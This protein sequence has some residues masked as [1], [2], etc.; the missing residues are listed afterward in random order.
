METVFQR[1][2]DGSLAEHAEVKQQEDSR[3]FA[4]APLGTQVLGAYPP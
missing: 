2:A 3:D 4:Q 1:E